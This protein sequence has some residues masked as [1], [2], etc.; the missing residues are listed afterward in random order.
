MA[1]DNFAKSD[2]RKDILSKRNSLSEFEIIN[3]SKIINIRVIAT[4]EYQSSKSIGA[5]YPIGSEVKTF[6]IIKHSIDNKKDIGLPRVLDSTNIEFFKIIEDSF[7]KIKFTKGKYGIFENTMSNTRIDQMDLLIIPG[8][9]F[10]LQGNR[11]GYGKGYY[12]RLLSS[13]KAKYIIG[14]AYEDQLIN[15]IPNNDHDIPVNIIITEKRT[16][17]I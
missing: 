4:K 5:Y 11:L 7:E 13:R 9:A 16:I 8:I 15:E 1:K 3:N 12:D 2:I 14:L 6:E 10:D 17:R